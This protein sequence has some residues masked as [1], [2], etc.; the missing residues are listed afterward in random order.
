MASDLLETDKKYIE[1]ST[2]VEI[3]MSTY[4]RTNDTD[5]RLTPV[6]PIT[7]SVNL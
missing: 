1:N 4:K 6:K 7:E 2:W 5:I 3:V